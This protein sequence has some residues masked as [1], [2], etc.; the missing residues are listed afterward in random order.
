MAINRETTRAIAAF[1]GEQLVGFFCVQ[2]I[3]HLEPLF[4]D[5]SARG[6]DVGVNLV[7][8]MVDYLKESDARGAMLFAENPYSEK[9]A[10]HFGMERINFPV[11]LKVNMGGGI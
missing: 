7:S 8:Q 3:P 6:T 10:E 11:Y 4:V 5:P 1:H 2:L 9:L